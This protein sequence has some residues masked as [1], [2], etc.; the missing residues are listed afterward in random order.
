MSVLGEQLLN[1]SL[2]AACRFLFCGEMN[3]SEVNV[4]C[5]RLK[6]RKLAHEAC[7]H[8]RSPWG[9]VSYEPKVT[10]YDGKSQTHKSAL[11]IAAPLT[12][13]KRTLHSD[14]QLVPWPELCLK[15]HQ[16]GIRLKQNIFK[17]LVKSMLALRSWTFLK[18]SEK[19][20][21]K[22]SSK[23]HPNEKRQH[24]RSSISSEP[25]R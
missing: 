4:V 20:L 10:L 6:K 21:H 7:S 3:S 11:W 15:Q 16:E 12:C 2:H 17:A 25:S 19:R 13:K 9:K 5:S 22:V 1:Q 8:Y 24:F 23:F 18:V 14:V